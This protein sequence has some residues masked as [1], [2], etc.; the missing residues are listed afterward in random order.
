MAIDTLALEFVSYQGH[1]AS[2]RP[3]TFDQ[4]G[5][6]LGRD[7][8]NTHQLPDPLK[9]C[10][11]I[12]G[13]ISYRDGQFHYLNLSESVGTE[14]LET[15]E[16]L[17]A[18]EGRPL[19][20]GDRLG[21][22]EYELRVRIQANT[23]S[24]FPVLDTDR[25]ADDVWLTGLNVTQPPIPSTGVNGWQP[26]IEIESNPPPVSGR[27]PEPG[28]DTWGNE[29]LNGPQSGPF[30]AGTAPLSFPLP[31]PVTP[32]A[33]V[34]AVVQRPQPIDNFANPLLEAFMEGADLGAVETLDE[35]HLSDMMRNAG[36]LL[37]VFL[38]ETMRGL[39]LRDESKAAL[40]LSRTLVANNLLKA[41]RQAL[42]AGLVDQ[43]L[44][45]LLRG[46]CPGFENPVENVRL[47]FADLNSH[48]LA[49][50]AAWRAVIDALLERFDPAW[51][52]KAAEDTLVFQ[53]KAKCWDAY[54]TAYPKIVREIRDRLLAE[55]F[56]AAYEQQIQKLRSS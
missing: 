3:L 42:D 29:F 54:V 33:E 31:T 2:E 28:V 20:D 15:G 45:Y 40:D 17:N 22:G 51:Y 35:Q 23:E 27:T 46:D 37:R 18:G 11:R 19:H 10:S 36:A 52:E 32:P 9:S 5:G 43:R 39:M 13:K 16:W 8:S 12:H 34:A 56:A 38:E 26:L 44:W 50:D 55:E 6:T 53:R 49:T 7:A 47:G 41:G 48:R 24:C 4:N 21:V 1:P 14:L 25:S 30:Q